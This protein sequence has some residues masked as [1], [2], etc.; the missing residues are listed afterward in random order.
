MMEADKSMRKFFMPYQ[1]MVWFATM[2]QMAVWE[3]FL[4]YAVTVAMLEVVTNVES[5][6]GFVPSP[7]EGRRVLED[8]TATEML[9]PDLR[10]QTLRPSSPANTN[11]RSSDH[12]LRAI[13]SG[14]TTSTTSTSTAMNV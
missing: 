13:A 7:M 9:G 1:G 14:R 3:P 2:A 4:N 10:V 11:S 5:V 12:P 6:L 8:R